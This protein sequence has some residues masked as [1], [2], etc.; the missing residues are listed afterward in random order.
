MQLN[1]VIKVPDNLKLHG[2]KNR[3]TKTSKLRVPVQ[4]WLG[5]T[6]LISYGTMTRMNRTDV[7]NQAG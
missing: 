7:T 2:P 4:H 5:N 3:E 6:N 1:K